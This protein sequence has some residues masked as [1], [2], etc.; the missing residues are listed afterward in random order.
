MKRKHA[1]ITKAADFS[2]E[3]LDI[4]QNKAPQAMGQKDAEKSDLQ[5]LPSNATPASEQMNV[6]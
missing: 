6:E 5:V 4:D 3:K 1:D 2:E